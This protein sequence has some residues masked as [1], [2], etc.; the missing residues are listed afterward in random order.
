MHL[1]LEVYQWL[2]PI[3]ASYFIIRTF[4]QYRNGKYSPRNTIIWIAFWFGVLLLALLPDTVP[5]FI[6]RSLGFKDHINA[7]IFAAL[8]LLFLMV[9]Y[10]S[11]AVN[12]IEDKLTTLVRRIALENTLLQTSSATGNN[13]VNNSNNNTT[14]N[15]IPDNK[16]ATINGNNSANKSNDIAKSSNKSADNSQNNRSSKS[17][18]Y[19]N[20]KSHSKSRRKSKRYTKS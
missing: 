15:N 19:K 6:A 4:K 12:R 1:Q 11:A 17:S 5:N 10:L 14:K 3:I 9:F 7:I 8:A 2:G 18:K 16:I 13:I 20:K